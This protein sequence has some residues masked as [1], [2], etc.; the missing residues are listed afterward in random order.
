MSMKASTAALE[1]SA[2]RS[3]PNQRRAPRH[4]LECGGWP[5]LFTDA[6]LAS[7]VPHKKDCHRDTTCCRPEAPPCH[8][9]AKRG[10][11]FSQAPNTIS[12]TQTKHSAP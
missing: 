3:F 4:P 6:I 11:C 1:S 7:K 10:I 5:L 9:E 8:P 2:S 12:T